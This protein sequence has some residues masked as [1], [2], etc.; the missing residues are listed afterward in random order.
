MAKVVRFPDPT[1]NWAICPRCES[2]N[3][4]LEVD[5]EPWDCILSILCSHCGAEQKD[6]FV[7]VAEVAE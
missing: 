2:Q 1:F 6:K 7:L 5:G 3:F 4:K